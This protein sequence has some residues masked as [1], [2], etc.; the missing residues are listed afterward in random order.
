MPSLVELFQSNIDKA[1]VLAGEPKKTDADAEEV[2]SEV[3]NKEEPKTESVAS[4]P[5]KKGTAEHKIGSLVK[6]NKSLQESVS[7]E[8]EARLKLESSLQDLQ[9]KIESFTGGATND[10]D[11]EVLTRSQ[12]EELVKKAKEESR[13]D[14]EKESR[15]TEVQRNAAKFSE[16]LRTEYEKY[17]DEDTQSMDED[18]MEELTEI[19]KVYNSNPTKWIA[20]AEKHGVKSF[21]DFVM[22]RTSAPSVSKV[23]DKAGRLTADDSAGK[24]KD[25][26]STQKVKPKT[27]AEAMKMAQAEIEGND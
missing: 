10:G 2:K 13:L 4:E 20:Y 15:T 22:D 23:A 9:K 8:R 17:Y 25:G 18:V 16:L 21:A 19:S 14:L 6:K 7:A 3:V 11:A 27:I 12:V 1:D 24:R 5:V 26:T